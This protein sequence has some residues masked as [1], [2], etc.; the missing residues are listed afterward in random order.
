MYSLTVEPCVV[1]R[2]WWQC[3]ACE[4]RLGE[5]TPRG[6]TLIIAPY[7]NRR[8]VVPLTEAG[9]AATCRCGA[10]VTLTPASALGICR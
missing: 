10:E 3:P 9:I 6:D 8:Y 5:L 4:A 1:R 7:P 2:R